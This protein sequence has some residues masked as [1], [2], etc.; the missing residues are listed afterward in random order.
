MTKEETTGSN[1]VNA[2]ANKATAE[3]TEKVTNEVENEVI[4]ASAVGVAAVREEST[5]KNV[6]EKHVIGNDVNG[7]HRSEDGDGANAPGM[8]TAVVTVNAEDES[9]KP[10]ATLPEANVTNLTNETAVG[11]AELTANFPQ[12]V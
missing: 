3:S 1:S 6:V 10:M 7:M 9:L 8:T 11:E 4:K 2:A 5:D 12:K